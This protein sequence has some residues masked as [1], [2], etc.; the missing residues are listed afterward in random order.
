MNQA[1]AVTV[2]TRW[3]TDERTWLLVAI[4][5]VPVLCGLLM[6]LAPG[7]PPIEQ[8][9]DPVTED[10]PSPT[11]CPACGSDDYTVLEYDAD[12]RPDYNGPKQCESCPEVWQ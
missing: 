12:G 8:G 2:M 3:L 4:I 5:A 6:L 9:E 1:A 7:A 11:G 10:A